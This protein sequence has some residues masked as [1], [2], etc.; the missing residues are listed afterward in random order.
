MTD[1]INIVLQ[2]LIYI[3]FTVLITILSHEIDKLHGDIMALRAEIVKLKFEKGVKHP[4]EKKPIG[5]E[6]IKPI[7][8]DKTREELKKAIANAFKVPE[9]VIVLPQRKENE[10]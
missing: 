7:L 5:A 8:S 4:E 6:Q 1:I 9:K 10:Q 2:V 3:A